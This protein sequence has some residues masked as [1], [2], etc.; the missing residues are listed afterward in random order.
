[1][2]MNRSSGQGVVIGLILAGALTLRLWGI[3]FGLPHQYHPDEAHEVVRALQLGAGSFNFERVAKGGYFYLLFLEYAALFVFLWLTGSVRSAEDFAVLLVTDPS[4]FW[5][6]GRI[7]TAL[8]GTLTVAIVYRLGRRLYGAT[9]G[10]LAAALLAVTP[11]HVQESHYITVNVPVA[12]LSLATLGF[13]LRMSE[14]G[15]ARDYLLSGG[16]LGLS[17]QTKLS[18]A[19]LL[20]PFAAAHLMTVRRE[21]AGGVWRVLDRRPLL[22]IGGAL[23]VYAAGAPG[24]VLD[25]P[26][27]LSRA[28][29]PF[30]SS[31]REFAETSFSNPVEALEMRRPAWALYLE[32]LPE[33]L[34]VLALV[35]CL[36][37]IAR[38]FVRTRGADWILSLYC[39]AYFAIIASSRTLQS[40]AYLVLIL[41]PLCLLAARAT[42]DIVDGLWR[43]PRANILYVVVTLSLCVQPALRSITFDRWLSQEDTR[44][45]AMRW[46]EANISAGSKILLDAGEFQ[47]HQAPPLRQSPAGLD[48]RAKQLQHADPLKARFLK[49]AREH[50]VG[51]SYNLTST[52]WGTRVRALNDYKT[53]GYDYIVTS[54]TVQRLYT[55]SLAAK[56]FPLSVSFY[57]SLARD[58]D[59]IL[60][61]RFDPV[62]ERPGPVI[63]VY[64]ISG[65]AGNPRTDPAL[66]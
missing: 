3:G 51:I 39:L 66:P 1:M 34:G 9:A 56:L 10:A 62:G 24:I 48:L 58:P 28:L 35:A 59:L 22:A 15:D 54:D 4:P 33:T 19:A 30:T 14:R 53:E 26:R 29:T 50:Q 37:G 60:V 64:R 2:V 16:F 21:I 63:S 23:A 20:I 45:L 13:L 57:A 5:L 46:I 36:V 38:T 25:A 27:V 43:R 42:T 47:S 40:G 32:A 41:P 61:Q 8:L 7:T 65:S 12:L 44:T 49:L 52:V 11:L 55:G 31:P 17:L 18:S 6:I